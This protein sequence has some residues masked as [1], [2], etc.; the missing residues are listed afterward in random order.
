MTVQAAIVSHA[1]LAED[2]EKRFVIEDEI[3]SISEKEY[4]KYWRI[5]SQI[6][7]GE[8][9]RAPLYDILW[10]H[11]VRW[12]EYSGRLIEL[13]I[14]HERL[15]KWI[16]E[17]NVEKIICFDLDE[18][19]QKTVK[20]VA[21]NYNIKIETNN[22]EKRVSK[23]STLI[24]FVIH[25]AIFLLDQLFGMLYSIFRNDNKSQVAFFPFPDRFGSMKPV[26]EST[27]RNYD[28]ILS[29][30][31]ISF[32]RRMNNLPDVFT[33]Y[34]GR[35]VTSL[36]TPSTFASELAL[37]GALCWR[38]ARR[39]Y[40]TES[41]VQNVE[42]KIGIRLEESVEYSM[43]EVIAENPRA[44]LTS[45]IIQNTS[46]YEKVIVG[47]MH[48]RDRAVLISAVENDIETYYIPHSITKRYEILPPSETTMFVPGKFGME[49]LR[50]M[51]DSDN[52]PTLSPLGRPY[53]SK[54]TYCDKNIDNKNTQ[55]GDEISVMIVTQ[56]I[57]GGVREQF[58]RDILESIRDISTQLSV[59]IKVHPAESK[60]VYSNLVQNI[61]AESI[62]TIHDQ[63][64]DQLLMKSDLVITINS[65]VGME[66][67]LSGTACVVYN[68]QSP[69]REIPVYAVQDLVPVFQRQQDLKNFLSEIK[70]DEITKMKMD[71]LEFFCDN[72]KTSENMSNDI[73]QKIYN[74]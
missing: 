15:L 34:N 63:D 61:Q 37:C 67:M 48:P 52:L 39:N 14:I 73:A 36:A 47:G 19:H 44:I 71:Q 17:E 25:S 9:N 12:G 13:A 58:V 28:I 68:T 31:C 43:R 40:P 54:P 29:P 11:I 1:D 32:V 21:N 49:H 51:Y 35:P 24:S 72:V 41:I 8:N 4:T 20:D 2:F 45:V 62:V 6:D 23:I 74:K 3:N 10:P 16:K 18:R 50:S 46:D 60:S 56:P 30:L 59:D 70:F 64:L 33:K 53:L 22:N 7:T 42:S 26:L 66:A 69:F 38:I 57:K 5:F 65:N 55:I 27:D